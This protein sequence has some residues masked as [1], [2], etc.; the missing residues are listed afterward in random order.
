M[1]IAYLEEQGADGNSQE[2]KDLEQ[3]YKD[4]KVRFDQSEEF[5]N[6]ARE[7]VVKIQSGDE[8]CL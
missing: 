7:Y 6:K 8:H 2:L 3:F 4:A 1:L 5:A